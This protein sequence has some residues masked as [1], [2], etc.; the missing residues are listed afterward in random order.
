M[1]TLSNISPKQ[2]EN[3]FTRENYYSK[4]ANQQNSSWFGKGAESLGLSGEVEAETFK[5]L[6]YGVSPEGKKLSGKPIEP[7]K[8][9]AGVDLTFS[10]PKSVSLAAL[11]G[12]ASQLEQAHRTAVERTLE[13]IQNRY[14]QTRTRTP[15]GRQVVDTGNLLVAQFHHDTSRE[16]DPQLHTHCIVANAT[17][18]DDGKWQSVH[19][20]A[21]YNN[22]KLL[23]A[24]YSNELVQEIR[25]LGY[26]VEAKGDEFEIVGYTPQQLAHFSKR[27]SQI[28]ELVGN[29]ATPAQKAWANLKTRAPKG[30]EISRDQLLGWWKAQEEALSLNIKHPVPMFDVPKTSADAS[31]QKATIAVKDAIAHCSERTVA[32][33]REALEKFVL[34]E[35][36]DFS[37]AELEKAITSDS[38][39]LKTTDGRYTT[40]EALQRELGTIQLMQQGKAKVTPITHPEQVEAVLAAVRLTPGQAAA[41]T[42]AATTTDQF[43]AWQGVAGAGKTYALNQFKAIASSSGCALKGF[44][45]SAEA[46]KVLGDE[47]GIETTTVASLLISKTP[48]TPSTAPAIWI[49]D[50]AGLLSAK[51]AY[52]LLLKATEEK[53]RLL[54]V[55]DTRQLSAVEA[56]NP[57]KSLQKAGMTTAYLNQSLRQRTRDLQEAVD[58]IA[59][60]RVERG[61]QILEQN[62]RITEIANVEKRR[63]QL[64]SDYMSLG[65]NERSKTLILAGTNAE[66]CSLTQAIRDELKAEGRLGESAI[67]TVLK[68]KDL[69]H[70]QTCYTH[71]Y[72]VGDV[73][74]PT[75]Q[76]SSQGL[77]RF[78][79]YRITAVDKD[80]LTLLSAG[81]EEL[82]V[83]PLKFRKNIYTPLRLEIAVGDRLKWTQNNQLLHRRNGQEFEVTAIFGDA[84]QIQY[85]GSK[86]ELLN[87]KDIH[88]IDYALVSTVYSSQGKTAE[89]VL[90]AADQTLGQEDFYVATS[91]VK[92]DLML[93]TESKAELL[94]RVQKSKA[95]ENPLK[96]IGIANQNEKNEAME[97]QTDENKEK[98][99]DIEANTAFTAL[100]AL[101]SRVLVNENA[102]SDWAG[103]TGTVDAEWDKQPGSYW[104]KLDYVAEIGDTT[105]HLFKSSEL[106]QLPQEMRS[107]GKE[108][109]DAEQEIKRQQQP[110]TE[111]LITYGRTYSKHPKSA[112]DSANPSRGDRERP[113]S[114]HRETRSDR[115][116]IGAPISRD[117]QLGKQ[118]GRNSA[119][120]RT[121]IG[122]NQSIN[123]RIA[124]TNSESSSRLSANV[125]YVQSVSN[126]IREIRERFQ[127]VADSVRSTPLTEIAPQLG[128]TLDKHDK[129][130]WRGE[131]QIISITNDKLFFDHAEQK[132]GAGAIDFVMHVNRSNYR[133]AVAWL[134]E[135]S[136]SSLE[137]PRPHIAT[138]A[139]E[140]PRKPFVAPIQKEE[141]WQQVRSYLTLKRGLP[142]KYVDALYQSGIIYAAEHVDKRDRIRANA[143]FLRQ[144]LATDFNRSQVTGA[145]VRGVEGDF[146]GLATG[147]RRSEGW[148]YFYEGQGE[149]VNRVV[150]TEAPI[151]TLSFAALDADRGDGRTLYL[152]T[153]GFGAIPKVQ[154]KQLLSCGGQVI[155]AVDADEAGESFAQKIISDLPGATRLK[156][157]A[158]YK[159]WN[160]QLVAKTKTL[161]DNTASSSTNTQPQ[162]ENLDH[163]RW[164]YRSAQVLGKPD[165]YLNTIGL[166][167][168]GIKQGK[169]LADATQELMRVDVA[170]ACDRWLLAAQSLD[171]SLQYQERINELKKDYQAG[172]TMSCKPLN[173]MKRD[174]QL[175]QQH[176]HRQGKQQQ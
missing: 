160:E 126:R 22:Q 78:V 99:T 152:S 116:P 171:K 24:I 36:K 47:T 58:L 77:D 70:I 14:A 30:S 136:V 25:K 161:I 167:V 120:D 6:L 159:D 86:T 133:E 131:G 128:L 124:R 119:S 81:G 62:R 44:A 166:V 83:D 112:A 121:H 88:H 148:F 42:L 105:R 108:C 101:N 135:Q 85:K 45:P 140:Q 162:A 53:A 157:D 17:R 130:K 41:V 13:A 71:Y 154:L 11:M 10:A 169:Q 125:G 34:S 61:F 174:I 156:P 57:F 9:R 15:S 96:L 92:V 110:T 158:A 138:T 39:L 69:T 114:I 50:E 29:D 90:I 132:G 155:V 109:C 122:R 97:N 149:K 67:A 52:A 80:K 102:Q 104:V 5:N 74:V 111:S 46:A 2:G 143:I 129:H 170:K 107:A 49:V 147:T 64:V 48:Q 115:E 144:S 33:K 95:K 43:V 59:R 93:Y 127:S 60:D 146:K 4:E 54:L 117:K 176:R 40:Q 164:W 21:F 19:N 1:L 168:D 66:R 84:A 151:D 137:N 145:S 18:L 38:E 31:T 172:K 32:F 65:L 72:Q 113:V 141:R 103:Y 3:Y 27:R 28:L 76:Y 51:D 118:D 153:D 20:D 63:Q 75:R 79:P 150:L 91:R 87:L 7:K 68:A 89:R 26:Q 8:H 23:G 123:E 98:N 173:Y 82:T 12:G 35:I 94:K 175:F 37:Y 106:S 165:S 56:G 163:L 100:I 55:G 134:S 73:V 139:P 16:K 142:A